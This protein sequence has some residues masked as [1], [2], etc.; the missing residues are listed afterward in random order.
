MMM[1]FCFSLWWCCF[2]SVCDDAVLLQ[3]VM[4]LFVS[5][6]D[7]A[8]FLDCCSILLLCA[9]LGYHVREFL[10]FLLFC[11]PRM[12][13]FLWFATGGNRLWWNKQHSDSMLQTLMM[14]LWNS[15]WKIPCSCSYI[16]VLIM[17]SF[18]CFHVSK[19][20]DDKAKNARN[21][22][23]T[24]KSWRKS[25]GFDI[26]SIFKQP[27]HGLVLLGQIFIWFFFVT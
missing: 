16:F 21:S 18:S 10:F 24:W 20:G 3:F 19:S 22:W 4:M 15:F 12:A 9:A 6:C 5:V 25:K 7:D 27:N 2:A 11:E 23:Q 1:L 26:T 13:T 17:L 14:N 8:V